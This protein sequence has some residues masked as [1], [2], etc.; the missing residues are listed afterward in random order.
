[1]TNSDGQPTKAK[2]P[3]DDARA[4]DLLE[5]ERQPRVLSPATQM[6][7][8]GPSRARRGETFRSA[9]TTSDLVQIIGVEVG[10]DRRLMRGALDR[11]TRCASVGPSRYFGARQG[12][13][14]ELGRSPRWIATIE[15]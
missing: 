11:Q 6:R 7:V 4:C 12:L 5:G 13:I 3:R 14:L 1:A 10:S 9:A 15:R 2:T 8:N